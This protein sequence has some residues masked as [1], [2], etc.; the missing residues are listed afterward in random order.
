MLLQCSVTHFYLE[1]FNRILSKNARIV[2]YI[3]VS[4]LHKSKLLRMR[5]LSGGRKIKEI[6]TKNSF[7]GT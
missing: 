2:L 3:D 6:S 5:N 4:G 7:F 1:H